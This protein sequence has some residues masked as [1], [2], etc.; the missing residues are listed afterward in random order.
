MKYMT[1]KKKLG[2]N[3]GAQ[4]GYAVAPVKIFKY[5]CPQHPYVTGL[6]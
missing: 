2:V 6:E 1:T 3:S 5:C 4:Q